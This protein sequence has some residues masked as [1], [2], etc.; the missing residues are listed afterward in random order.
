[1]KLLSSVVAKILKGNRKNLGSSP[2]SGPRSLSFGCDYMMA[3]GK[4]KLHTK[5]EVAS[6]SRYRNIEGEPQILLSFS[7]T[8]PRPFFPLVVIL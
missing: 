7:T 5:F 6:F 8:G 3:F 2:S 4:P 1:M